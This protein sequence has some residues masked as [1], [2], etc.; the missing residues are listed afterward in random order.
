MNL[1]TTP[2]TNK[3]NEVSHDSLLFLPDA[4]FQFNWTVLDVYCTLIIQ[5]LCSK[6]FKIVVT[7]CV[8][9][10]GLFYFIKEDDSHKNSTFLSTR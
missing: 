8:C 7:T 2:F 10:T 1:F 6:L 9:K 3:R 5:L 4:C